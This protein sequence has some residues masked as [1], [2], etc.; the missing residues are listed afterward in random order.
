M[1]FAGAATVSAGALWYRH[2]NHGYGPADELAGDRPADSRLGDGGDR[3]LQSG[4][5]D[6]TGQDGEARYG[7]RRPHPQ[8][9][10]FYRKMG[11]DSVQ[12][13]LCPHGCT[14]AA[15]GT[16]L[17]RV[18]ANK[19]GTLYS[20]VYGRPCTVNTGP[21]EK[22]PLYH[23]L[24]GHRR[25]CVATV[26]CNLRCR[27]CQN[28]YISQRG[29]G[30]VREQDMSPEQ[31]VQ[32]A[33]ERRVH[34]ISFTYTEPTVFY[35]YMFDISSLARASGL[36]TSMVSNGFINP[37]PLRS[38]LACI[39]AVKIDLKAFTEDFY[40]EITSA[41]LQPVLQTLEVLKQE[42]AH[43]EIVNLVV[44]A[45][46][47]DPDNIRKMCTW[48]KDRLGADVPLH[49]SRFFPTYQMAN[50]TATPVKTLE[51]ATEIAHAVGLE[52]VYIGNVPGHRHNSTFCPQC[53]ERLIYRSH[54]SVR[55]YRIDADRCRSCGYRIP[56]IWEG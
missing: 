42:Q 20:M 45:H 17:C 11:H 40:R 37:G 48:I 27:F 36:Q 3:N 55:E 5:E 54:F 31:I 9:A 2:D 44:P 47:D 33:L 18:R 26:G 13:Q 7:S 50:L 1:L 49:F 4:H 24:P 38:L 25:L 30:E 16:G 56:G 43:F 29:P 46:N 14:I 32:E 15:G 41:R 12:C 51:M 34:S 52:F 39:D 35:E 10:R 21:I 22:A 6:H 28:W 8:E 53:G 23:F 19:Q